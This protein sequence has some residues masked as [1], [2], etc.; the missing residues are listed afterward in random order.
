[1]KLQH[2]MAIAAAIA[3]SGPACVL[4][5]AVHGGISMPQNS[6]NR[7]AD[8]RGFLHDIDRAP[9]NRRVPG[10]APPQAGSI[11][12]VTPSEA[13]PKPHSSIKPTL[14]SMNSRGGNIMNDQVLSGQG[15]EG[16]QERLEGGDGIVP[17]GGAVLP[18]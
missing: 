11:H 3:L 10:L 2:W 9:P 4:A 13:W 6:V 16:I 8:A 12:P 15:E 7:P 14:P 17:P 18:R 1:M 5:Q